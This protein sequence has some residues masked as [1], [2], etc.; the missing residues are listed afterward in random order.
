MKAFSRFHHELLT[1][2]IYLPPSGYEV[3]FVST[4]H[5]D[6]DIEKTGRAVLESLDIV[7]NS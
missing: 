7:F 1:R 4:S 2:G 5:T 6:D 3:D